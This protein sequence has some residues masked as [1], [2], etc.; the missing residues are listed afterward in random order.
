MI[1][2]LTET[3]P[4]TKISDDEWNHHVYESIGSTL[5]LFVSVFATSTCTGSSLPWIWVESTGSSLPHNLIARYTATNIVLR[6]VVESP[7][8]ATQSTHQLSTD[9]LE[10]NPP[11]C[12]RLLHNKGGGYFQAPKIPSKFSACGGLISNPSITRG[13]FSRGLFKDISWWCVNRTVV[14]ES[15]CVAADAS[16][17]N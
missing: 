8:A 17:S 15:E 4:K 16:R 13:V 11:P 14:G 3:G 12:W 9:I 2:R 7:L 1:M 6:R 5:I 10:N